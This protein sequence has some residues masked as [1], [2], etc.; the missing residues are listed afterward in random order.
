MS[1]AR[2]SRSAARGALLHLIQD[3][4]SQS[5]VARGKE[6]S[7]GGFEPLVECTY[8]REYYDYSQQDSGEH[9]KADKAPRL[10]ESCVAGAQ[11]DDVVTA[12]AVVIWMLKNDKGV[13]EFGGYFVNRVIGPSPASSL[14]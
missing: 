7:A 3:S 1:A 2:L 6:P 14:N 10:G 4:Y 13:G 9:N 8:P 12:T 5:H 11:A